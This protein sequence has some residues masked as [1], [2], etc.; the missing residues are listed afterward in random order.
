MMYDDIKFFYILLLINTLTLILFYIVN[1]INVFQYFG[2]L[3]YLVIVVKVLHL[4]SVYC[5]LINGLRLFLNV[6]FYIFS[7]IILT[8]I[9]FKLLLLF[10]FFISLTF[11]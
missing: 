9:F 4:C 8:R 10:F 11:L 6:G 2:L 3:H 5:L 1:R 7:A